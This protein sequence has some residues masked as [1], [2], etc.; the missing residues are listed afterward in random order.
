MKKTTR[1]KKKLANQQSLTQE[2]LKQKDDTPYVYQ[3]RKVDITLNIKELPWT[4]K[5]KEFMD[6]VFDKKTNIVFCKG[7]SG[8]AKTTLTVYCGL[9]LLNQRKVSDI[10]YIRTPCESSSFGLGYLKGAEHE[11]FAPYSFPLEDKL[12]ELLSESQVKSLKNDERIIAKPVGFIRGSSFNAKYIIVEESQNLKIGDF[13]LLMTRFGKF[14]KMIFIGD[15]KQYDIKNSGFLKIYE[16]FQCDKSKENGIFNFEFNKNDIV[17][18][19]ILK[20]VIG[21]FEDIQENNLKTD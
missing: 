20:F 17:R 16:A 8:T 14:S 9:K 6:L 11:K 5:Q 18:S 19:E 3:R 13:L 15:E 4:D 7:P 2:P 10:V 21:K 1:T 12:S